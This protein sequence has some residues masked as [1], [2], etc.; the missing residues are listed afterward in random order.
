[1]ARSATSRVATLS[2]PYNPEL[3]G[4]AGRRN[5]QIVGDNILYSWDASTW[6][7]HIGLGEKK[8]VL[9]LDNKDL[10]RLAGAA[11]MGLA[12]QES[13]R[14]HPSPFR[15]AEYVVTLNPGTPEATRSVFRFEADAI[16]L[17]LSY[18]ASNKN[19]SFHT[20]AA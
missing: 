4:A 17:V 20:E 13:F 10:T 18:V 12:H 15:L 1:M 2:K 9:E 6:Q 5:D 14:R 16:A 8:Q 19:F 7:A 11:V 3:P